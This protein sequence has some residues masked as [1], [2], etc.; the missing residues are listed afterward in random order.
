V[1]SA[2]LHLAKWLA[3]QIGEHDEPVRQPPARITVI[4]GGIARPKPSA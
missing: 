4:S 2:I 3:W 1:A